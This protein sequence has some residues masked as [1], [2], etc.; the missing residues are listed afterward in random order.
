VWDARGEVVARGAGAGAAVVC[1]DVAVP[2]VVGRLRPTA[3]AGATLREA[4]PVPPSAD[5]PPLHVAALQADTPAA[6]QA[7][8]AVLPPG[9][10][11]LAIVLPLPDGARAGVGDAL[12]ADV[13]SG[14]WVLGGVP[15]RGEEA[16]LSVVPADGRAIRVA[17]LP[18][19]DVEQFPLARAA[20][21]RGAHVVVFAGGGR[22]PALLRARASENRVFV[23]SARERLLVIGPSGEV[24]G[25]FSMGAAT[26]VVRLAAGE[27]ADKCVAAGTDVLRDAARARACAV[28]GCN[29]ATDPDMHGSGVESG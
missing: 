9:A 15:E 13:G 19:G 8:R 4:A 7:L 17:V 22:D 29:G 27:A 21:L 20:A 25:D 16:E 23:I 28:I 26:P 1:A 10:L 14:M 11:V 24:L 18:G 6:R 2:T 3:A 5:V 12:R